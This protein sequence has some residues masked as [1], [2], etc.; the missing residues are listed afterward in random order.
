MLTTIPSN[1]SNMKIIIKIYL[2]LLIS[3]SYSFAQTKKEEATILNIIINCIHSEKELFDEKLFFKKIDISKEKLY[4]L[5]HSNNAFNMADIVVETHCKYTDNVSPSFANT[6]TKKITIDCSTPESFLWPF[7]SL[8]IEKKLLDSIDM[9]LSI[10]IFKNELS[11][12]VFPLG[13]HLGPNFIPMEEYTSDA[14]SLLP[15]G[16]RINLSAIKI[17]TV[18]RIVQSLLRDLEYNLQNTMKNDPMYD[19]VSMRYMLIFEKNK[20][21]FL[22]TLSKDEQKKLALLMKPK[23]LDDDYIISL[24]KFVYSVLEKKDLKIIVSKIQ[25]DCKLQEIKKK[26]ISLRSK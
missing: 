4:L 14:L 6:N 22:E 11:H 25:K 8:G 15:T 10:M 24:S 3:L 17:F 18:T 19:Y 21:Y 5:T 1:I 16:S 2:I 20:Q 13:Q 26:M 9:E 12:I 7:R 23:K